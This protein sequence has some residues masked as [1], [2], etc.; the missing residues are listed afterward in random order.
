LKKSLR[1]INISAQR[2]PPSTPL[3]SEN[4]QDNIFQ[5][6]MGLV[7]LSNSLIGI[8]FAVSV[9]GMF[10]NQNWTVHI[11]C[12]LLTEITFDGAFGAFAVGLLLIIIPSTRRWSVIPLSLARGLS[13]CLLGVYAL[14]VNCAVFGP[15]TAGIL[16][17]LTFVEI[18]TAAWYGWIAGGMVRI[19]LFIYLGLV[20]ASWVLF[21]ISWAIETSRQ[22]RLSGAEGD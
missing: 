4:A 20:A 5:W 18:P 8:A 22:E 3:I 21:H 15:T 1:T 13:M 9:V 17:A 19:S 6:L 10:V 16:A 7:I 2:R 12:Q 11:Y 14:C